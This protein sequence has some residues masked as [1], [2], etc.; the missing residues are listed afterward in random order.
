MTEYQNLLDAPVVAAAC[1]LLIA[2][3]AWVCVRTR[4]IRREEAAR[5]RQAQERANVERHTFEIEKHMEKV[6][7]RQVLYRRELSRRSVARYNGTLPADAP[8][9]TYEEWAAAKGLPT[10]EEVSTG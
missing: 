7:G 4:R 2:M 9:P 1:V 3:V 6:F 10:E 5:A 8:D